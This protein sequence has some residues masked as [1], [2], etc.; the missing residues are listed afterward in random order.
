MSNYTLITD[1]GLQAATQ[2]TTNGTLI[3]IR[4]LCLKKFQ[5]IPSH[6]SFL[7]SNTDS[8]EFSVLGFGVCTF[9]TFERSSSTRNMY[10]VGIYFHNNSLI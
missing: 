9:F 3:D 1:V 4:Y 2:A 5:N 8:I 6:I 10:S 7:I